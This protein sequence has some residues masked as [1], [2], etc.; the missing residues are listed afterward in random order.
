MPRPRASQVLGP[1]PH[2]TPLPSLLKP[3][4][5]PPCPPLTRALQPL[6]VWVPARVTTQ[7][8][9]HLSRPPAGLLCS[10]PLRR[11]PEP[12]RVQGVR[13]LRAGT[14]APLSLARRACA[15]NRKRP[16]T[17]HSRPGAGKPGTTAPWRVGSFLASPA[18]RLPGEV[19]QRP[20]HGPLPQ[21]HPGS[22]C[23][24]TAMIWDLRRAPGLHRSP[25]APSRPT[26]PSGGLRVHPEAIGQH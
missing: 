6:L 17:H 5:L 11:K 19:S 21:T 23:P 3:P 20:G 13:G 2:G 16:A 15:Q 25:R 12:G 1:L 14:P 26:H 24:S 9:E 10:S 18:P 8:W 22:S 7:G 4:L